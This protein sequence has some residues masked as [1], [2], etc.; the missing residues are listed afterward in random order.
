MAADSQIR[1]W[2]ASNDYIT[3]NYAQARV[4]YTEQGERIRDRLGLTHRIAPSTERYPTGL[5][6]NLIAEEL[7]STNNGGAP[8]PRT[9]LEW[10]E[11][12]FQGNAELVVYVKGDALAVGGG[13]LA[14]YLAYK[15]YIEELPAE[16]FGTLPVIGTGAEWIEVPMLVSEDGTF[17]DFD[18]L[19]SYT[20]REPARP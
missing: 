10:L 2:R 5:T 7:L 11:H 19:G 8:E 13:A 18:S 4:R 14:R 6:L 15:T 1:L 12:W 20:P 9:V 3:L 17:S 16:Y